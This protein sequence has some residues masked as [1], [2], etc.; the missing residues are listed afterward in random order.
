M[1]FPTTIAALVGNSNL[2]SSLHFYLQQLVFLE[3]CLVQAD[4]MLQ[5]SYSPVYW[6][7]G[8]QKVTKLHVLNPEITIYGLKSGLVETK[9]NK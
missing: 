2:K 9:F 6:I 8:I 1:L 7:K 3:K 4:H 5:K